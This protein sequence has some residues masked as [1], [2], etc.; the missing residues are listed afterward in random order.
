M[1]ALWISQFFGAFNDN[2]WKVIVFILAT[3]SLEGYPA[4]AQVMAT[5]SLICFLL[6]MLLFS[7]PAGLLADRVSKQRVMLWMKGVED[8]LVAASCAHLFISPTGLTGLFVFLAL[9]GAQSALFS[10]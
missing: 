2:A 3:R 6:P 7:L 5:L 4:T 9:M 1:W 10:P 8:V